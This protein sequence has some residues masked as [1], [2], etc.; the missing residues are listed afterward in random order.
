MEVKLYSL[1]CHIWS[2]LIG[3]ILRF[4]VALIFA[5]QHNKL[6]SSLAK[7]KLEAHRTR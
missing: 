1:I 5:L 3:A 4:L 7:Y 6:Y 2:V